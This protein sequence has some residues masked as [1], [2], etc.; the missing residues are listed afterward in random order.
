MGAYVCAMRACTG[1]CVYV[2][3]YEQSMCECVCEYN[4]MCACECA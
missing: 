2:C 3:E 1:V 4:K